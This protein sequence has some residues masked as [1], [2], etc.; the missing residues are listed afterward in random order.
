MQ[1][2][3]ELTPEE[4]QEGARGINDR[5][6]NATQIQALVRNMDAS[7]KRWNRLKTSNR[8]E[9]L[10]KLKAENEN[11]FFNYPAIFDM[12]AEDRLDSTFFEMLALKRKIEKGELTVDQASAMIGQKMFN[13][14][15]PHVINQGTNPPAKPMSYEDYY[16]Q[17]GDMG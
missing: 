7:K 13:R 10:A 17:F 6:L 9:Y 5:I 2:V 4:I 1:Q 12:H 11:L 15:V 16:K 3:R 8:T 14:Y